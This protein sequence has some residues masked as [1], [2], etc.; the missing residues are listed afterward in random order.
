MWLGYYVIDCI[1]DFQLDTNQWS[2]RS[3]RLS[4]GVFRAWVVSRTGAG[5]LLLDEWLWIC[6]EWRTQWWGA[7]DKHANWGTSFSLCKKE[8]SALQVLGVTWRMAS[9]AGRAAVAMEWVASGPLMCTH[10]R[11]VSSSNIFVQ[12][13]FLQSWYCDH[14]CLHLLW[15]ISHRCRRSL[16]T[17]Q[18][19]PT[20]SKTD[21]NT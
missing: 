3:V 6:K 2:G 12:W 5:E 16:R 7:S 4:H 19:L 9:T 15:S 20:F 21:T 11:N 8:A 10:F 1:P 17:S 14:S 13:E 18:A